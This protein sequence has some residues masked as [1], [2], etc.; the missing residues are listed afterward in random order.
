MAEHEVD[1][2]DELPIHADASVGMLIE[3]LRRVR[4]PIYCHL[5]A[6]DYKVELVEESGEPA[7]A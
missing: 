1:E 2:Q 4:R 3:Y 7:L 5:L 6:P